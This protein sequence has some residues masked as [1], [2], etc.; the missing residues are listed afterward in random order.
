MANET[1]NY[2]RSINGELSFLGHAE[3]LREFFMSPRIYYFAELSIP[4]DAGRIRDVKTIMSLIYEN[5]IAAKVAEAL[6]T[7]G[8]IR[9][10]WETIESFANRP[11]T[12]WF[13]QGGETS[14]AILDTLYGAFTMWF[15]FQVDPAIHVFLDANIIV[16]AFFIFNLSSTSFLEKSPLKAL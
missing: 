8:L 13:E 2:W 1:R 16:F 14:Y 11:V 12:V 15:E 4:S 6:G 3:R 5:W 9:R 7:R 10:S